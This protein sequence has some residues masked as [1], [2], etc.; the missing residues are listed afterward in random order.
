MG[1]WDGDGILDLGLGWTPGTWSTESASGPPEPYPVGG[2]AVYRGPVEPGTLFC[3]GA[4]APRRHLRPHRPR[5]V[6]GGRLPLGHLGVLIGDQDGDGK[7]DVVVDG[8]AW[9]AGVPGDPLSTGGIAYFSSGHPPAPS[10]STPRRSP[11]T[12]CAGRCSWTCRT[13][14]TSPATASTTSWSSPTAAMD[15][16]VVFVAPHLGD[17]TGHHSLATA[18]RAIIVH[19]RSTADGLVRPLH[20]ARACRTSTATASASW[21]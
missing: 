15:R 14:A 12:A 19:D 10:S 21:S 17:L 4:G 8:Y 9:E 5:P 20:R 16:G 6:P 2:L 1:D 7:A 13:S 18:S 3:H 11:C